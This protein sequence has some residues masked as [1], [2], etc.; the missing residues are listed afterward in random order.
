M[1]MLDENNDTLEDIDL[2][3]AFAIHYY[4]YTV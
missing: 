1:F 4:I 2:T 3:L